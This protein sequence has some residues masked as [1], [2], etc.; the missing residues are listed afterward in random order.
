MSAEGGDAWRYGEWVGEWG[1]TSGLEA[2]L[3]KT[4]SSAP[5]CFQWVQDEGELS[6]TGVQKCQYNVS[7]HIWIVNPP[8][9]PFI[10]LQTFCISHLNP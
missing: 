2:A 3:R 7:H 5:C 10:F 4:G 6:E 8:F 9:S 1:S